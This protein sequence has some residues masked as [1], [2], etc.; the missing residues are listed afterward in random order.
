VQFE[1]AEEIQL[2]KDENSEVAGKQINTVSAI[3]AI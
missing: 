3:R 1:E 2:L